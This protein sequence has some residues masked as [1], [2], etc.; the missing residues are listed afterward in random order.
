MVRGSDFATMVAEVSAHEDECVR[1][2]CRSCK[3]T[4]MANSVA[5]CIEEVE[6]AVSEEVVGSEAA[7]LNAVFPEVY[8]SQ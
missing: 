5:R 7:D 2:Y 6:R 4:Q 3:S 8:L 1:V